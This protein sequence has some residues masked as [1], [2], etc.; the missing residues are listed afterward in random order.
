MF[1]SQDPSTAEKGLRQ[2]RESEET[3]GPLDTRYHEAWA[4]QV[5]FYALCIMPSTYFDIA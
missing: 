2:L 1:A 3:A 4:K 5:A